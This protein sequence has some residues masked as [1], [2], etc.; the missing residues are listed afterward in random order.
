MSAPEALA[1]WLKEHGITI[2]VIWSEKAVKVRPS[3]PKDT[4]H[5]IGKD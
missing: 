1:M 4:H 2:E 5:L 3:T